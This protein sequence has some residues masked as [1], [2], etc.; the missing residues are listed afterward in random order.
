[1]R[2]IDVES[3]NRIRASTDD[4]TEESFVFLRR[5]KNN[6]QRIG[7]RTKNERKWKS[8]LFKYRQPNLFIHIKNIEMK[9]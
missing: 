3:K 2:Q 6:T 4:K 5:I 1:M 7:N 9:L 8:W